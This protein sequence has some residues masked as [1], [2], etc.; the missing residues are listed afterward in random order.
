MDVLQ[1][2]KPL[3]EKPV[4]TLY[5]LSRKIQDVYDNITRLRMIP[6]PDF[7]KDLVSG[8]EQKKNELNL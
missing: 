6:K 2:E 4:F 1:K 8:H 3:T 5:E 7:K